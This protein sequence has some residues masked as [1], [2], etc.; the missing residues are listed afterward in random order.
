MAGHSQGPRQ[1]SVLL[2]SGYKLEKSQYSADLDPL[3]LGEKLFDLSEQG[4]SFT[5]NG[6]RNVD[7]DMT[8]F[9][10]GNVDHSTPVKQISDDANRGPNL[11]LSPLNDLDGLPLEHPTIEEISGVVIQSAQWCQTASR[12]PTSSQGISDHQLSSHVHPA[13]NPSFHPTR[14]DQI[15]GFHNY[16]NDSSSFVRS[17]L[18]GMHIEQSQ[19]INP[20]GVSTRTLAAAMA[21]RKREA[22]F[23]CYICGDSQTSKQ[24]MQSTRLPQYL[25]I[26]PKFYI[27][28]HIS[29]RHM[30]L[31]RFQCPVEGCSARYGHAR[32]VNRHLD[33]K[34][35]GSRQVNAKGKQGPS[36]H[37]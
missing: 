30:Q 35:P 4:S 25:V 27:I 18:E 37:T 8:I 14:D 34:H 6:L 26:L 17:A 19:I 23:R 33:G 28:D 15:T 31:K 2:G 29:S 9:S 22:K 1:S 20:K 3:D 32:G 36:K 11:L 5:T 13:S 10:T 21:N 24:N 12:A 7:Y 16:E